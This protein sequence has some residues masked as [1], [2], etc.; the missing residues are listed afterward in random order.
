MISV[1]VPVYNTK[2]Y[3]SDCIE[4]ILAQTCRDFE[5]ILI[6]DGSTDGSGGVCDEYAASDSRVSV[7]HRQNMGQAVARN[8]GLDHAFKNGKIDWIT[9]IDSD[10]SVHEEY[11]EALLTAAEANN[12][13]VNGC[14]LDDALSDEPHGGSAFDAELYTPEDFYCSHA[15]HCLTITAKLFSMA[16]IV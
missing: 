4:S 6:D 16:T 15:M 14:G 13:S 8:A 10:D 7:I 9:F 1:I 3:L 12:T 11:L 2:E 5:L